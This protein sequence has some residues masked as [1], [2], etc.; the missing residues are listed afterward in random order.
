MEKK[1]NTPSHFDASFIGHIA[2]SY[3]IYLAEFIAVDQVYGSLG[4]NLYRPVVDAFVVLPNLYVTF[5]GKH[6]QET[7]NQDK[8]CN[9]IALL[10]SLVTIAALKSF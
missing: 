1:S 2:M 6:D 4:Y 8:L 5:L 7:A 3:L 10:G 9:V